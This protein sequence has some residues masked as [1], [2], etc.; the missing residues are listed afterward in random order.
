[1]T[2]LLVKSVL[3]HRILHLATAAQLH[4]FISLIRSKQNAHLARQAIA[5][6]QAHPLLALRPNQV[7]SGQDSA[8]HHLPVNLYRV[9][10]WQLRA[11]P[12]ANIRIWVGNPHASIVMQG[13]HVH[14]QA[15]HLS[16]AQLA[17][18][19]LK[20]LLP[21]HHVLL[22]IYVAIKLK[23]AKLLAYMDSIYIQL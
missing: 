10:Q 22:G 14:Q 21:V 13:P 23:Q 3:I 4:Y 9:K 20:A 15:L 1:L 8:L 11:V 19:Q 17:N 18:S 7:S 5:V 2:A 16:H 12:P 6:Q